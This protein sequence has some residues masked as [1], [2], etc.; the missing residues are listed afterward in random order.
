MEVYGWLDHATLH[1]KRSHGLLRGCGASRVPHMALRSFPTTFLSPC[2]S[3]CVDRSMCTISPRVS[4]KERALHV[5][6]LETSLWPS[7]SFP[8]RCNA[9]FAEVRQG[10][11]HQLVVK[12]PLCEQP[13]DPGSLDL[14]CIFYGV[15]SLRLR[16]LSFAIHLC[17][18]LVHVRV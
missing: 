9:I 4:M 12:S 13:V 5:H 14:S 11:P 15:H 10:V 16:E 1:L 6:R 17:F 8:A 2:G 18:L 7:P 3:S